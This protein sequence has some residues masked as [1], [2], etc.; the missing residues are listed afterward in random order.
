LIAFFT[1]ALPWLVHI[2]VLPV[3]FLVGAISGLILALV[4]ILLYRKQGL[5]VLLGFPVTFWR[6]GE[7][8]WGCGIL[9]DC[10]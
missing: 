6:L 2:S 7:Y 5:W 8:L 1:G 3:F 9:G 4:T 10:L